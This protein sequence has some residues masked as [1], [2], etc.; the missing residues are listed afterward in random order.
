MRTR[1]LLSGIGLVSLLSLLLPGSQGQALQSGGVEVG[2][3]ETGS[4]TGQPFKALPTDLDLRALENVG[5]RTVWYPPTSILSL[6][7]RAGRPVVMKVTN[8]TKAEEG[9]FLSADSAYAAPTELTV[10]IVLKPG[11][12]KYIGIPTSDLTYV[13]AG[14][15]LRYQS[16]L[17]PGVIG[18]QLM[19]IK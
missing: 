8:H 18:G 4:V 3:L 13:T 14:S 10:K 11:E 7:E 9:F 12:T 2:D 17:N 16:H 6:R 19:V 5:G 15:V 1:I